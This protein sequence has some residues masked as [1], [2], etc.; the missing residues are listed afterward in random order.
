MILGVLGN[1]RIR[2]RLGVYCSAALLVL[3]T[4]MFVHWLWVS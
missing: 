2:N 4:G 3:L 1:N